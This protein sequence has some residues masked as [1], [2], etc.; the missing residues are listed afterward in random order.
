MEQSHSPDRPGNPPLESQYFWRKAPAAAIPL[1]FPGPVGSRKTPHSPSP[2]PPSR[3]SSAGGPARF[4]GSWC[5]LGLFRAQT[6]LPQTNGIC[7]RPPADIPAIIFVAFL[8]S[9]TRLILPVYRAWADNQMVPRLDRR[10]NQGSI[11]CG[12]LLEG[13]KSM[14]QA[15]LPSRTMPKLFSPG[16]GITPRNAEGLE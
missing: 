14:Q 16:G 10:R 7:P 8:T 5:Y 15:G 3:R 13:M 2:L 11:I 9:F 12:S 1:A 6:R 4:P